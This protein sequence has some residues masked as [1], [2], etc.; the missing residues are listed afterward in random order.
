MGSSRPAALQARNSVDATI[1]RLPD[2]LATRQ[3]QREA[4]GPHR[5]EGGCH[6][7]VRIGD[8]WPSLCWVRYSCPCWSVSSLPLPRPDGALL[9]GASLRFTR[10][11]LIL[12]A[13]SDYAA[14]LSVCFPFFLAPYIW[15]CACP[16]HVTRAV[17]T[18][19]MRRGTRT[20]GS[21]SHAGAVRRVLSLSP[22]PWNLT[23]N[24]PAVLP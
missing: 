7:R 2:M 22:E 9:L 13:T 5:R 14:T 8:V 19:H 6:E 1:V 20:C 18:P 10:S 16:L 23:W 12:P 17:A 24:Q 4:S 21:T 11:S 15:A 3:Q